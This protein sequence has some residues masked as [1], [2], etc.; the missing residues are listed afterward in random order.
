M[1][2]PVGLFSPKPEAAWSGLTISCSSSAQTALPV[3]LRIPAATAHYES[4]MRQL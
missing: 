4:H 3:V 1:D 2:L